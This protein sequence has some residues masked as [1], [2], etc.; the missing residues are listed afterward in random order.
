MLLSYPKDTGL[1]GLGQLKS[2]LGSRKNE[3]L[4]GIIQ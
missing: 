3:T 2:G 1:R 4:H